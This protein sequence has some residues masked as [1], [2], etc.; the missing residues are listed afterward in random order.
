MLKVNIK[1]TAGQNTTLNVCL[2]TDPWRMIFQPRQEKSA[3]QLLA[4]VLLLSGGST[5]L[6]TL[7]D[8]LF[9]AFQL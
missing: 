3:A 1:L 5:V 2:N 8:I 4:A 6:P 9:I 7:I